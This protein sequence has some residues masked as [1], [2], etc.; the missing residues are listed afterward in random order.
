MTKKSEAPTR[1]TSS[2]AMKAYREKYDSVE[3]HTMP[4]VRGLHAQIDRVAERV[5]IRKD[6]TSNPP[7]SSEVP[8]SPEADESDERPIEEAD[9][10]PPPVPTE[11]E[12]EREPRGPRPDSTVRTKG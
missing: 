4:L 11:A 8:E 7:A 9:T 1:R 10:D 6:G 5:G 3:E 12:L 2:Q